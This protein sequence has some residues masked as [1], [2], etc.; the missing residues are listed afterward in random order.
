MVKVP[1]SWALL[2]CIGVPNDMGYQG[3]D[4]LKLR[5]GGGGLL[6]GWA[7]GISIK[8]LDLS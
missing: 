2:A 6:R 3:P 7:C 5:G 4:C 1:H 8:G